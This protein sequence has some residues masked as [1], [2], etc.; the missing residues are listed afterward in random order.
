MTRLWPDGTAIDMVA[1]ETGRPLR[2]VWQGRPH[3]VE[4]ITRQ[5]RVLDGWWRVPAW[6]AYYKLTT[7]SGLLVVVYQD[8]PG[9]AWYLQRLFD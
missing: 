5:W 9:G 3:E 2:F 7:T 4:T 6:R 1:D 8:L